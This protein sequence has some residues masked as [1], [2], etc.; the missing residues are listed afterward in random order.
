[1]VAGAAADGFVAGK[2]SVI[3]QMAAKLEF[4]LAHRV[5]DRL[6]RQRNAGANLPVKITA[7]GAAII[8]GGAAIRAAAE[9]WQ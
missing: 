2:T 7:Q 6:Y 4:C 3:K 1:M 8:D 5:I 9:Q